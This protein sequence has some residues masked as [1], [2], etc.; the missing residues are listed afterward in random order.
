[1]HLFAI[2]LAAVAAI[3][4]ISSTVFLAL[5][6]IGSRVLHRVARQQRAFEASLSDEQLP[7]VSLLKPLHGLE[8][9]LEENLESFFT[10]DY[11]QFEVLFAV[12]HA[13]DKA[14]EVA[15]RVMDRHPERTSQI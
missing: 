2:L 6:L 10:Q 7:F 14:A 11:P 8:P 13:D 15:R 3:G 12:D 5:A 9:Q 1:M 4:T